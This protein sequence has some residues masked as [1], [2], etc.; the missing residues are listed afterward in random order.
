VRGS[1]STGAGVEEY[2]CAPK[3]IRFLARNHFQESGWAVLDPG[4]SIGR[5]RVG[6]SAG[7]EGYTASEG[8]HFLRQGGRLSSAGGRRSSPGAQ[9]IGRNRTT[10][11]GRSVGGSAIASWVKRGRRDASRAGELGSQLL[12][13]GTTRINAMR[14]D[15]IAPA[16][17]VGIAHGA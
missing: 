9:T 14:E 4:M 6:I 11:Q 8:G 1:R 5:T 13:S 12:P 10:R 17:G 15:E 7:S 16:S 3:F 2:W